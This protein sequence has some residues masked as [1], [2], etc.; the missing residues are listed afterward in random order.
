M[1]AAVE[2]A[3]VNEILLAGASDDRRRTVEGRKEGRK[4]GRATG[5]FV[6]A[7]ADRRAKSA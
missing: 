7:S 2:L 3:G 4:D 6:F 5:N 1:S